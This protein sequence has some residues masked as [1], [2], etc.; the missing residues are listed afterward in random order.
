MNK[1]LRRPM[2]LY[3][4][5]I[6]QYS[7]D[8]G[9]SW[10][11]LKGVNIATDEPWL[12]SPPIPRRR[13]KKCKCIGRCT[14]EYT[15]IRRG[16]VKRRVRRKIEGVHTRDV[17]AD[18]DMRHAVHSVHYGENFVISYLPMADTVQSSFEDCTMDALAKVRKRSLWE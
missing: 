4:K 15:Y 8:N 7:L 5:V 10:Q 14:H 1:I 6:E 16:P 17:V 12:D 13:D 18:H 2:T 9:V 3:G 11:T